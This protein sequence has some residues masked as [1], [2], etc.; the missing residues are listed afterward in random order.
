MLTWACP[1]LLPVPIESTAHMQPETDSLETALPCCPAPS[2]A[3]VGKLGIIFEGGH[4][5]L[6][7]LVA[8]EGLHLLHLLLDL[9][10]L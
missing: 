5:L 1:S 2:L 8:H 9:G 7:C 6:Q 10:V 4:A 3:H